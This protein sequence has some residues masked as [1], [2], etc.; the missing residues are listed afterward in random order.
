MDEY[1]STT[2]YA[3]TKDNTIY[4]AHV[5]RER[6]EVTG[7]YEVTGVITITNAEKRLYKRAHRLRIKDIAT[8]ELANN[9]QNL[10]MESFESWIIKTI[11]E[12]E[13]L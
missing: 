11:E 6:N 8:K 5:S 3:T 4:E 10:M 12:I 13:N 7:L 9:T 2:S 1:M